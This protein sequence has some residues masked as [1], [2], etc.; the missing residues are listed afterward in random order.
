VNT[1]IC[2][3]CHAE[4]EL[5]EFYR[6]RSGSEL[7]DKTC[8]DCRKIAVR[9]RE[10]EKKKLVSEEEVMSSGVKKICSN[11]GVK[12]EATE[13]YYRPERSLCLDSWCI[14]CRRKYS[15]MISNREDKQEIKLVYRRRTR[16]KRYGITPDDYDALL[17]YQG[18]GCAICGITTPQTGRTYLHVDHDH[19]SDEVRGI[20]CSACNT[21]LG[22]F[23]DSRELLDRAIEYLDLPPARRMRERALA[24]VA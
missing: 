17:E 9:A 23:K 15:Q 3:K 20:L 24:E 7:R 16:L 12:K 2:K 19:D 5:T 11:C 22:S 1:Q 10:A 8:A 13:F 18:G 14:K 6:Q 21:A 4:K